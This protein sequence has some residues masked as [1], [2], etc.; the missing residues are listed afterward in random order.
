VQLT[1]QKISPNCR[2]GADP[3]I[4]KVMIYGVG[5]RTHTGVVQ[6]MFGALAARG[7]NIDM[8]STSEICVSLVVQ[9]RQGRAAV[10][11]LREVFGL[12]NSGHSPIAPS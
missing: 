12:E 1:L 6:K 3:E 5:I 10:A 11:A 2:A 4:A 7:I 9:K 8:I